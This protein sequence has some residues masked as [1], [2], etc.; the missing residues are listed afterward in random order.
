MPHNVMLPTNEYL[1]AFLQQSRLNATLLSTL[2]DESRLMLSI[3][4]RENAL[5]LFF[6]KSAGA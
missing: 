5:P 2:I 4:E 1:F 3:V 6:A